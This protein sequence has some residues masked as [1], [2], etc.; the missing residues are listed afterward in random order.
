MEKKMEAKEDLRVKK[1][2]KALYA[3][4]MRLLE[5]KPFEEITVNELCDE[6]DVRRATFYK[7]YA[8]KF[9]FLMAFTHTLRDRF[10]HFIWK[11]SGYA[12]STEYYVAYAKG[13]VNYI[14]EHPAAIDNIVKSSLFSHMLAI[15]LEQNYKDTKER[16][17]ESARSGIEPRT[18]IDTLAAMC[19]GGTAVTIY[20]WLMGGKKKS[21]DELADEIGII[22]K[23]MLS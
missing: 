5:K 15:I 6:A 22:I 12:T 19:A 2:K 7:H 8:D 23:T 17:E 13:I 14:T 4:F 21:P 1:T 9:A 16:L 20:M 11:D 3:A 10:D 18:S